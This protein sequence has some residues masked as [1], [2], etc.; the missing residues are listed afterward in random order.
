MYVRKNRYAYQCHF[1]VTLIFDHTYHFA[2]MV[3]LTLAQGCHGI[4]RSGRH[5]VACAVTVPTTAVVAIC[6]LDA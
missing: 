1:G 6:S 3:G 2:V 5:D 4:G